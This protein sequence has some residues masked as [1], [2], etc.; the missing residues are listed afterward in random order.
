[1]SDVDGKKKECEGCLKS[2]SALSLKNTLY[3]IIQRTANHHESMDFALDSVLQDCAQSIC[4]HVVVCC[5]NN[6]SDQ[7]RATLANPNGHPAGGL[8]KCEEECPDVS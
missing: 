1:M 5:M 4:H 6:F 7:T 8:I 3:S 2:R